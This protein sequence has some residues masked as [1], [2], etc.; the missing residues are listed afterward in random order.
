MSAICAPR[1]LPCTTRGDVNFHLNL[2]GRRFHQFQAW[3]QP[4]QTPHH[5][6]LRVL[7]PRDP[8]R[9]LGRGNVTFA[10]ADGRRP[11]PLCHPDIEQ[12][13]G[14]KLSAARSK[15]RLLPTSFC[16]R[17]RHARH[18]KGKCGHSDRGGGCEE[19]CKKCLHSVRRGRTCALCP[20]EP[21]GALCAARCVKCRHAGKKEE[22]SQNGCAVCPPGTGCAKPSPADVTNLCAQCDDDEDI[23]A[24]AVTVGSEPGRAAHCEVSDE[25]VTDEE[26]EDEVSRI[27]QGLDAQ[28]DWMSDSDSRPQ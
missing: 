22:H 28:I 3:Q 4:R 1:W 12:V 27:D 7:R 5:I 9:A 23:D 19:A 6:P 14:S 21:R 11:D 10:I 17:C 25:H 2:A 18:A 15:Q 13:V 26:D 8:Q 24:C 20:Q 16:G